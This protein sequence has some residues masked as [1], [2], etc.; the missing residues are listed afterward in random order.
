MS[1][2]E[3]KNLLEEMKARSLSG[4]LS[5]S[6]KQF[7]EKYYERI[8]FCTFTKRNCSRCYNDAFI[9]MYTTFK[10]HGLRPMPKFRLK[11]GV[12]LQSAHFKE[13]VSNN[14][15]TDENA[16]LWLKDNPT[17][18]Y[19][20]ASYPEDWEQQIA[21]SN[22]ETSEQTTDEPKAKRI[23]KHKQQED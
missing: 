6:D 5:V 13:V 18:I 10:K 3:I 1:E 20:F 19:L 2:Q 22:D 14:N 12:V 15:L 17:R 23:K 21:G 7:I 16:L 9:E 11:N 8:T 4:E